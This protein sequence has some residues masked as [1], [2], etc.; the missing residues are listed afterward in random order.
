[1]K[2]KIFEIYVNACV[3]IPKQLIVNIVA[4]IWMVLGEQCDLGIYNHSEFLKIL[5]CLS[6]HWSIQSLFI[7]TLIEHSAQ[8]T[9]GQLLKILLALQ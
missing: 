2:S 9:W 5:S 1:M 4:F 6:V 8:A 7:Q 3:V